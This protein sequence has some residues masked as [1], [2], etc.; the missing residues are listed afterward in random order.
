M[1]E[2][3]HLIFACRDLEAGVQA[4]AELTGATAVEGGRHVG[5][6][7]RNSLLTF[8]DRTYFEI[9]AIDPD[10]PEP[11]RPRSFGLDDLTEPK[12]VAYAIHP[13]GDETLESVVGRSAE[14]GVD[15]GTVAEMSRRKPDGGLLSWR[16]TIGGDATVAFDGAFPF[17]ID[18][19]DSES[20]AASLPSM[21]RLV[22][23]SVTNPDPAVVARVDALDVG[24]TTGHG[25]AGL[26]ATVETADG[27]VEIS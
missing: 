20:P 3:D 9:I 13:T 12:L 2:L 4:I 15:L 21:G 19:G 5:N 23:L 1:A 8:D 14:A 25:P 18:W 10:Q 17:V 24:V 26:V 16:L 6:G 11:A 27:T 7:T 22:S